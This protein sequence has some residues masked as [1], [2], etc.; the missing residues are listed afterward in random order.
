[1]AST[2]GAANICRML[3]KAPPANLEGNFKFAQSILETNQELDAISSTQKQYWWLPCT[4]IDEQGDKPFLA[5]PYNQATL[6]DLNSTGYRSPW[7]NKVHPQATDTSSILGGESANCSLRPLEMTL[8]EIWDTYK[9]L[10]YGHAAVGSVF[11][12]E[13]SGIAF[14]GM[15]GIY[16]ECSVGT[17]QSIT[18]AVVSHPNA[19][20]EYAYKVD[21][22]VHLV[23]Q[24][25]GPVDG[26][27]NKNAQATVSSLVSKQ[28][29]R[30]FQVSKA[31]LPVNLCHI[32]N[33][34]S[35]IEANE[36]DLRSSL[37][38]VLIPKNQETIDVLQRKHVSSPHRSQVNPLAGMMMESD[39]LKKKLAKTGT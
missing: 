5:C 36:I 30:S 15:F 18:R 39:I 25:I 29:T 31:K 13:K 27:S 35:L 7:T 16:K 33:L 21:T 32:E 4:V 2:T 38:K 8:N 24:P 28:T 1:M 37:E 10:Y 9:H 17:W 12:K 22:T 19:E 20:G 23:L 11:L 3:G 34:G 26:E 6:G 14:E